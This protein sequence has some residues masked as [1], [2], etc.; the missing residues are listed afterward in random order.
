MIAAF[1]EDAGKQVE[2]VHYSQA[3]LPEAVAAAI[4]S[5]KP[6]DVA[7]GG[8]LAEYIPKWAVDDRLVGPFGHRRQLF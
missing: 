8:W 3:E 7:F 1:E 4:V 6:P 2:L 5:G